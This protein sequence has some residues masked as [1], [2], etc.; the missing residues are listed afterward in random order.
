MDWETAKK[1]GHPEQSFV[2]IEVLDEAQR[3]LIEGF[4]FYESR[5]SGVGSYFFRL[6][7]LG[8]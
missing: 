1:E 7:F 6:P 2:K 4:Q 3:D 5:E 8:H